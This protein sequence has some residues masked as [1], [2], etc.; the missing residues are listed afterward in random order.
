MII[1]NTGLEKFINYSGKKINAPQQAVI[2]GVTSVILVP[3]VNKHN[4]H[5]DQDTRD[6]AVARA[7]GK[8]AAGNALDYFTRIAAIFAVGKLSSYKINKTPNEDDLV[9]EISPKSLKKDIFA[10]NMKEKFTPTP[11]GEFLKDYKSYRIA[12]GALLATGMALF[13]KST[14]ELTLTKKIT[15]YFY[16]KQKAKENTE[17]IKND[18]TNSNEQ[19]HKQHI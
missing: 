1:R 11:K 19:I 17:G 9:T 8:N 7:I 10:P 2:M 16:K 6:M 3:Y 12:M 4:K 13:I 5:V 18:K 15:D 14:I